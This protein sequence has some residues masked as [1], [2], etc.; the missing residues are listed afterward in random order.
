MLDMWYIGYKD[1]YLDG[2][3]VYLHVKEDADTSWSINDYVTI[4]KATRLAPL[5]DQTLTLFAENQTT[6]ERLLD[7]GFPYVINIAGYS[8]S[9]PLLIYFTENTYIKVYISGGHITQAYYLNG[10][11]VGGISSTASPATTPFS[12]ARNT[13]RYSQSITAL[14]NDKTFTCNGT[15]TSFAGQAINDFWNGVPSALK[16][17]DPYIRVDPSGPGGGTSY[18][19]PYDTDDI[20]FNA[21]PEV[22]A[23]GTGFI[24][25]WCPTEQQ[26]LNLS[27]FMWNVDVFTIEFWKKLIADPMQLIYGLNIIPVDLRT[28]GIVGETPDDVVVGFISTGIKM[29]YLTSQWVEV[30]CGTLE[31]EESMLGSYMDYDPYTKIDIYLPYIGYRPL[32]VDDFMPGQIRLKYKIDLLTGSCIAQIK[33]TKYS[34]HDD[35]LN[36]VIYQFMGNCATQIPVTASQYADAVRSAITTAAA[37]GTVALLAG[38]GGGAGA[39]AAGSEI[40]PISDPAGLLGSPGMVPVDSELYSSMSRYT[41]MTE[42][43]SSPIGETANQLMKVGQVHSAAS[44]ANNVM[45]IKPSVERS[46]AIGGASGMMATQT[47]Y[48]VFTRPNIAHPEQ[49]NKYTGY[50]SFITRAL[51]E[52]EGFTQV[53]AIHLEGIPCT[54][55][56]LAEIDAL[57]KS[58]VI[59]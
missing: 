51:S 47:P 18:Y 1:T 2:E 57:L 58:G 50:P 23:I 56:E 15:Y 24:S 34:Y 11:E 35:K 22:S 6:V 8:A 27:A 46:G 25:L 44:A 30:D 26:M 41:Y 31:I 21:L 43:A 36:S 17:S 28:A 42:S 55:S 19:D 52:L 29:D 40:M 13:Y 38:A 53:Q 5:F 54:A 20:D 39:V 4:Y 48:L 33:A 16:G 3:K 59:F 10:Q 14:R 49:Q 37:I 9:S 32:R 12:K 45:G 7:A